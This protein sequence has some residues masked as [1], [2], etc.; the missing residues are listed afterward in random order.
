VGKIDKKDEIHFCQCGCNIQITWKP[1]CKYNGWPRFIGQH[2]HRV[3]SKGKTLEER[4]GIE[5]AKQLKQNLS[6]KQKGRTFEERYGY[7]K[8]QIIK[9]KLGKGK[10]WEQIYGVERAD[11]IRKRRTI[12]TKEKILEAAKKVWEENG[13]MSKYEFSMLYKKILMCSRLILEKHFKSPED[14]IQQI[15][16]NFIYRYGGS[17]G[18]EEKT[19]LD[20]IEKEKN[21]KLIRQFQISRKFI[22]G[23]DPINNVA[24]E[25]DES[26]HKYR[27]GDDIKRQQLIEKRLNCSIIRI[28]I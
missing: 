6:I 26:H 14:L 18:K 15:G 28:D 7:E 8:A 21:I 11:D 9:E 25:I 23:Y 16:G 17:I 3:Y 10:T 12:W 1:W 4:F 19:I 13:P 27:L 20:K 2:Y 22:D 5:K 24:Y